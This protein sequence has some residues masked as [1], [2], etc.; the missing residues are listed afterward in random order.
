MTKRTTISRLVRLFHTIR[1]LRW[2]QVL[3][4]IYYRYRKPVVNN[5]STYP[6]ES[7]P[8]I[9]DAP[10]Y[11]NQSLFLNGR[12]KLLNEWGEL[13]TPEDWNCPSKSK[14]WLYNVHYFDD[15]N[16]QESSIR[17]SIHLKLVLKWID[18]N[19]PC[20]GNGWEPYP[21]SLRMVNWVKWLNSQNINNE[22][23]NASLYQQSHA[24]MQQLEFH[25]LGNHLFANGK[26]LVFAGMYLRGTMANK[27]LEKGLSILRR[28]I[29]EQFLN[30]GGHFER[31]P[32]Y[33]SILLWDLL[34][35]INL[36]TT[37]N[38]SALKTE[39]VNWRRVAEKALIP[40]EIMSH[41]DGKIG[42]FNDAAFEIAPEKKDILSYANRLN[43]KTR[44][45]SERVKTLKDTG[46]SKIFFPSYCLVF[47]HG[48]IGPDYLPGHAHADSLS[49]EWSVDNERVLVNSGTDVYGVSAER[50][51]QRSTSAHNTVEVDRASSSDVWGG[52]RVG[53]RARANVSQIREV[54]DSVMIKAFHDGYK[55]TFGGCIH[56]R[57]ITATRSKVRIEDLLTGRYDR[58]VAYFHLHPA[59]KT[60]VLDSK[61]IFLFTTKKK[62]V[63]KSNQDM[64]ISNST[65]HPNFGIKYDSKKIS[66]NL[67][68]A[69]LS[70][71]MKIE[72]EV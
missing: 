32:M 52:F 37:T 62:I 27:F 26:A 48:L 70:V 11:A 51:R 19:E 43:I 59:I 60:E 8:F 16:S 44:L 29:K 28:E 58:A 15:L 34:D 1:Y 18:E 35:L 36:A 25:I 64:I 65:W 56:N 13:Q 57:S 31:S 38:A 54:S 6:S 42:F 67:Q 4:R 61:T 55:R 33:H 63:F 69:K 10:Q 22:R 14:L 71:D 40:L 7:T 46:F 39:V 50:L 41:S 3:Y 20:K 47:D 24:L 5:I 66:I 23:V 45:E 30:D 68:D 12:I 53:K 72:G 49:F 9:W 17:Q 2:E 21:I